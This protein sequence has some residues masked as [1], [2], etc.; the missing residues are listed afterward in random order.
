MAS[1]A[2]IFNDQL[3]WDFIYME[4][5]MSRDVAKAILE[6]IKGIMNSVTKKQV[7]F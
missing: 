1:Q 4:A 2:Q 6:E 3:I 5:D 7:T